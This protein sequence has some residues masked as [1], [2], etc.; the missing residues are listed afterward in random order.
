MQHKEDELHLKFRPQN[1]EEFIGGE[2]IVESIKTSLHRTHTFL[3]HGPR[4]CGK[5]TLARLIGY[6][7]GIKDIG[8]IE[9]DAADKTGVDDTRKLKQTV[10]L[11]SLSGKN[12]LYIIDECHRLSGSAQDSLLKTLEEPP[13]HVYFVLCTT[14]IRK[15]TATIKSRAKKYEVKQL[16]KKNSLKLIDWIC[17][18]EN[19]QISTKLK[20]IIVNRCEG[21][22]R[23]I[24][25]TLD[26]VRDI[27]EEETAISLI[28]GV[29]ESPEVIE[30]ISL[31]LDTKPNR[32]REVSEILKELKEEPETIRFAITG[33]FSKV[34]LNEKGSKKADRLSL[35]IDLF[36]PTFIYGKKPMLV[37]TCYLAC[38]I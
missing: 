28:K 7:L 1:F 25:I 23:E 35:L 22:P 16:S 29:E 24:V 2:E 14:D 31:L 21:I 27:E 30:L 18:E 12:K 34:L 36:S 5:T 20:E 37:S 6:E 38:K 8:I 11:S 19:I 26:K 33:Y 13:K 32:W 17:N 3:F 15:V 9:I 10:P 4:G